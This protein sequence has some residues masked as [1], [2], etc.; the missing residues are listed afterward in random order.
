MADK[1]GYRITVY[2]KGQPLL[3]PPKHG[4]SIPAS[5]TTGI[6]WTAS[7]GWLLLPDRVGRLDRNSTTRHGRGRSARSAL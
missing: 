3:W 5:S 1:G 4:W 6:G 2:E 7:V